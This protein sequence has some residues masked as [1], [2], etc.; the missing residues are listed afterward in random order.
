M[1]LKTL[2]LKPLPA[3]LKGRKTD[4]L[5]VKGLM[6]FPVFPHTKQNNNALKKK[7][8]WRATEEKKL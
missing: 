5:I 6:R 3:F 8:W 4:F 1:S 7:D 2:W